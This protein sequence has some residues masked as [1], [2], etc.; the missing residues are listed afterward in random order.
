MYIA[1]AV[2]F[3]IVLLQTFVFDTANTEYDLSPFYVF[4]AFSI[5]IYLTSLNVEENKITSNA[6]S[7][8]GKYVFGV[9]MIQGIIIKHIVNNNIL[10]TN[11]LLLFVCSGVIVVLIVSIVLSLFTDILLFGAI[12]R[13]LCYLSK[14]NNN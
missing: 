7:F 2:S 5:Y 9:C 6:L 3:P 10:P 13:L 14:K 4:F 1:G 11:N 12:R 8:F